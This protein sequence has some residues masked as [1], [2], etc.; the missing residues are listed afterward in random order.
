MKNKIDLRNNIQIQHHLS[1]LKKIFIKERSYNS[2]ELKFKKR[3]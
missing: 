2:S 1:N 3:V